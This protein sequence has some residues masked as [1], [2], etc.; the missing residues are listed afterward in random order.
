MQTLREKE[1]VTFVGFGKSILGKMDTG[2]TTSSLHASDIKLLKDNNSVSF[3]CADL[4]SNII[5]LPLVGTQDVH[6]SDNGG[7]PR[8]LVAL[9][10]ELAGVQIKGATFNLN[11]RSGMDTN[12]LIGKNVLEQGFAVSVSKDTEAALEGINNSTLDQSASL[13]DTLSQLL[14]SGSSIPQILAT[15]AEL[16]DTSHADNT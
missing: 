7:E 16:I 15:L 11:D 3:M 9:D 1:P 10:I 5:Q 12:L 14:E 4:G 2:A 6:T 8:H 13:K